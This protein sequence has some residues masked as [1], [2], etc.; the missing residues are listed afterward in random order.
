MRIFLLV[1]LLVYA[2]A[3]FG[4]DSSVDWAPIFEY[5]GGLVSWAP[6]ALSGLGT[7]VVVET[8]IDSVVP[9]EKD[10]GFMKKAMGVPVLGSFLGALSR[11]SPFNVKNK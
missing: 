11:F 1:T 2:G 8:F 7:L 4:Q 3:A 9:D 6:I 5:L 10:G